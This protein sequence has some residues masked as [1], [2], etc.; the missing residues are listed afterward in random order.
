MDD[1]NCQQFFLTEIW[2]SQDILQKAWS[3]LIFLK[4]YLGIKKSF[5]KL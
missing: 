2:D 4:D 3:Q 5:E 1:N